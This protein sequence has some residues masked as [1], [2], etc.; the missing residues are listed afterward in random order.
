M[1]KNGNKVVLDGEYLWVYERDGKL[2]MRVKRSLNLYKILINSEGI[3][4]VVFT[5]M[6]CKL[7][8]NATHVKQW[9]GIWIARPKSAK[10]SVQGI[11][12]VKASE[13]LFLHNQTLVQKKLLS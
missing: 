1:S 13:D 2:L 12:I 4:V 11:L 5:T 7:P 9:N 10:G 6:A 8:G 3:P